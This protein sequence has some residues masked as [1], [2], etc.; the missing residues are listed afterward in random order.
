MSGRRKAVTAAF[1]GGRASSGGGIP[2]LAGAG[3]RLGLTDKLATPVS[4][5]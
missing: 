3:C 5:T 4:V 2:L 1:E